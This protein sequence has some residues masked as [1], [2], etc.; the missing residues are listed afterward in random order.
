MC[1]GQAEAERSK[2]K[3]EGLCGAEGRT[4]PASQHEPTPSSKNP[5]PSG[6]QDGP[7]NS[8]QSAHQA[9]PVHGVLLLIGFD[10][11]D[12][13]NKKQKR[14]S[15]DDSGTSALRIPQQSFAAPKAP[16]TIPTILVDL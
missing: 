9:C 6:L 3:G 13:L 12:N 7:P 2:G 10:R 1:S 8:K 11:R 15:P 14:R 5:N 4:A 16:F